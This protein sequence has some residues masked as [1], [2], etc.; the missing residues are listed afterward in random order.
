MRIITNNY[1][2]FLIVIFII[3]F[4]Q[5]TKYFAVI[6]YNEL[7]NGIEVFPFLNLVFVTN[8][9]I[10]FGLLSD[11]NISFF[12]GLVSLGISIILTFWLIRSNLNF[13]KFIISLILGGALG[14]GIDRIYQSYVI[15]F[16]DIHYK[17]FHWPAFNIADSAITLG[18]VIYIFGNVKKPSLLKK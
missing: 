17:N 7:Q 16:I 15:D 9:G 13:E 10:S 6:F 14:N 8:K 11:L 3:F 12:L 5:I 18:V 2:F 4:D 1:P